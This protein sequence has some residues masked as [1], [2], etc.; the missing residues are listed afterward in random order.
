MCARLLL[1]KVKATSAAACPSVARYQLKAD[2]RQ[3]L[4]DGANEWMEAVGPNRPFLGGDRPN[5]A[6]LVSSWV[7]SAVVKYV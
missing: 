1:L 4:Y 2:V 3:S 5:L 6:D 7:C